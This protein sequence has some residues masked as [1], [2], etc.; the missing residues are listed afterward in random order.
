[1]Y[2]LLSCYLSLT[3]SVILQALVAK[4][5]KLS[6]VTLQAL[7]AKVTTTL[8]LVT[9]QALCHCQSHFNIL[10]SDSPGSHN[11]SHQP[12][13]NKLQISHATQLQQTSP[14]AQPLTLIFPFTT[15]VRKSLGLDLHQTRPTQAKAQTPVR[16]SWDQ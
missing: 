10:L 4:T 6:L 9:L 16:V 8:Y 1:M 2:S 5:T 15:L 3:L 13:H 7:V 14:A 12:F 11:Q